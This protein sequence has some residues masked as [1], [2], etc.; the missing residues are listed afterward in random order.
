MALQ[1]T[2]KLLMNYLSWVSQCKPLFLFVVDAQTIFTFYAKYCSVY[3]TLIHILHL[4]T[5]KCITWSYFWTTLAIF[6][7]NA[8]F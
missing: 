3:S 6:D 5:L 7:Q 1:M 4:W 2:K 8:Y